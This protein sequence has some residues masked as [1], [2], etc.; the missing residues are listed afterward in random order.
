MA[1]RKDYVPWDNPAEDE[2]L[3]ARLAEGWTVPK[4]S[5]NWPPQFPRRSRNSINNR[6]ASLDLHVTR[7]EEAA[8][9]APEQTLDVRD[10][11][12]TLHV[13]AYGSEVRT[14]EALIARAQID[15]TKYEVDRP[16][17]SMHEM[18]VRDSEGNVRK[19]QNF[20]IV[21][22]FRLKAGPSVEERV[23]AILTG[24]FQKRKPV[25]F[26]LK[27]LGKTKGNPDILQGVVIADPHIAKLAWAEGTGDRN[28][29]TAI[30][31]ETLETGVT[32]VM[33]KGLRHDPGQRDFWILGDYFH[34]DGQ[35][36]TTK[37][38]PLDYDSRVQK[39]LTEG[40]ELLFR[41]VE[42]SAKDVPTRVVIV[43]GNHDKILAYALQRILVSEFRKH[44]RVTIDDRS[45][46]TKFLQWGKCLIGLDHGDKGKK[47]LPGLMQTRCAVEWGQT[48]YRA[49]EV[50]HLHARAMVTTVDGVVI[51][52]HDSLGAAD[53]W[54]AEEKF[55]G[56]PRTL[57]APVYHKGGA[58]IGSD[59][60]SP[61]LGSAPRRGT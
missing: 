36:A 59:A 25:Q 53:L 11:G 37:G 3:K 27:S 19:V 21:A 42:S 22:R 6:K 54:H 18:T 43:P 39:M 8:A 16:E 50:G 40:S 57:Q 12:T 55:V 17:T 24:A 9:T 30:S 35:G 2:W 45:T 51:K 60:W 14:L 26:F 20:R 48:I 47:R 31:V 23:D 56:S 34:H 13:T 44:P 32:E 49:F 58:E 29:D 28:Y 4:M 7:G 10:D 5:A 1:P 41:L 38:T 33:G 15:T 46:S 61:D 52:T